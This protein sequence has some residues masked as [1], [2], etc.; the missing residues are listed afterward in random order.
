MALFIDSFV[1]KV[2]R[3]GRVSVPA[4]FRAAL[5]GQNFHGIVA[6]PSFKYPAVQ[7]AGIDWMQGLGD[8]LK[9]VDLFS[10]QHDDLTATLFPDAKQLAFDGEGR[11]VLPDVLAKH[12][13]IGGLAAFVG[14]GSI[15][16]IW[17]PKTF[18]TYKAE[19]RRRAVEQGRTLRQGR[20]SER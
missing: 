15:F 9:Q 17:E 16:E 13:G 11:I 18:E 6:L 4:T 20:E 3:K 1:N 7:C 10:D 5:A 8:S 2:D 14:R 19:A 12:A